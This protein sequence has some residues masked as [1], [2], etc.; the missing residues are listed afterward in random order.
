[1]NIPIHPTVK[2]HVPAKAGGSYSLMSDVDPDATM[3]YVLFTLERTRHTDGNELLCVYR[4]GE[5]KCDF[6]QEFW[7]GPRMKYVPDYAVHEMR[8][9]VELCHK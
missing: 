4:C 3:K 5:P 2:I 6:C 7:F 1:M 9:H 8:T